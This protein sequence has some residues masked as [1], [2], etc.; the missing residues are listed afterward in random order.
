[1]KKSFIASGS[2]SPE[3]KK[4]AVALNA[5]SDKGKPWAKTGQQRMDAIREI[6]EKVKNLLPYETY[7]DSK[8]WRNHEVKRE[9]LLRGFLFDTRECL[10]GV[11]LKE[12]DSGFHIYDQ[13]NDYLSSMAEITF[14]LSFNMLVGSKII[15]LHLSVE[16]LRPADTEV[17]NRIVSLIQE[18]G[19]HE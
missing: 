16:D 14:Y 5:I 3:R 13:D 19:K 15:I 4:R 10:G 12:Y 8:R 6:A 7:Y 17:Y 1:M 2:V 9:M 11:F 18:G